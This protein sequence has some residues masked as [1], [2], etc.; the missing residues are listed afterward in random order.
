M[1]T[2]IL[3]HAS[4]GVGKLGL[5]S[6][7]FVFAS[8][9]VMGQTIEETTYKFPIKAK[10][11]E[12]FKIV[13]LGNTGIITIHNSS[14]SKG[15]ENR[16][17]SIVHL[18]TELKETW[19]VVVPV[20][21]NTHL[22]DYS[23]DDEHIFALLEV[24]GS[25]YQILKVDTK[26]GSFEKKEYDNVER[27][28]VTH[29]DVAQGKCYLGG[30]A[31]K[32]PAVICYD[33]ESENSEI[34]PSI[35]QLRAD[36]LNMQVFPE[37]QSVVVVLKG[38]N[39]GKNRGLYI[40]QYTLDGKLKTPYFTLP[41][42]HYNLINFRP[43]FGNNDKLILLGDYSL[44]SD[45]MAQGVF[46]LVLSNGQEEAL[47]FYDFGYFKNFFNYMPEKEK[48]GVKDRIANKREKDK[49]HL[50]RHRLF[51]HKLKQQE[52]Q[53]VFVAEEASFVYPRQ[54]NSPFRPNTE[55]PSDWNNSG[56]WTMKYY[57][58]NYD[59]MLVEKGDHIPNSIVEGVVDGGRPFPVM[60]RYKHAF[61]CG[62]DMDGFLKWDNSFTLRNTRSELP[63]EM[64]QVYADKKRVMFIR[65]DRD[66]I[67]F[68]VSRRLKYNEQNEVLPL[69][70]NR[71]E[72]R[73]TYFDHG[74][75][76]EWFDNHFIFTG[77]RYSKPRLGKEGAEKVFFI[78]KL[79][80]IEG[81]L[82]E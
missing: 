9:F 23:Q 69:K 36:L 72:R 67:H 25:S 11:G 41:N 58:N 81:K 35:N 43:Y 6:L 56:A 10:Q 47:R 66:N 77:I 17:L 14:F 12:D 82:S 22:L 57:V 16:K 33:F 70:D 64:V 59:H 21:K 61:A 55:P 7:L 40:N 27:I 49:I 63:V 60:F 1:I 29:F 20:R 71:P 2:K 53:V 13:P 45:N 34:L 15:E 32:F 26:N 39:I 54:N 80:L 75:V 74:G 38:P 48:E 68:K 65:P 18:N 76:S 44:K 51:V 62:F 19:S 79:S 5:Y 78:S 28:I 24:K 50:L 46:S 30:I 73:Q 42:P 4:A 52:N 3:Q 37:Q 8:T 31:E